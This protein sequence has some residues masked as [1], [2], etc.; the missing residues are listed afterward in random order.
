MRSCEK[1]WLMRS[2]I[3]N[4]LF[5][6]IIKKSTRMAKEDQTVKHYCFRHKKE[7]EYW[8][9]RSKNCKVT[10]VE[11]RVKRRAE[12]D[13]NDPRP[14]KGTCSKCQQQRD[15][16]EF[17]KNPDHRWGYNTS[18]IPCKTCRIEEKN[19]AKEQRK[20]IKE[21][22][23][24]KIFETKTQRKVIK[25]RKKEQKDQDDKKRVYKLPER[26]DLCSKIQEL[27]SQLSTFSNNEEMIEL[28]ANL[29]SSRQLNLAKDQIIMSNKILIQSL[30]NK[31]LKLECILDNQQ[32]AHKLV[33]EIRDEL[34]ENL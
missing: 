4:I 27:Q 21:Q 22:R 33:G 12:E 23:K 32:M 3:K 29:Y 24:Q 8:N 9:A 10:L 19:M 15:W 1:Y 6:D 11:R 28:Q 16:S 31:I 20:L 2:N 25:L 26:G 7:C 18:S 34:K 30:L 14:D 17:N 13:Q 5:K